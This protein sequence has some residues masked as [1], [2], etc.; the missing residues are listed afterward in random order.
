MDALNFEKSKFKLSKVFR[1]HFVMY[2][3]IELKITA[4]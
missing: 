1:S 3:Y 4:L 2:E